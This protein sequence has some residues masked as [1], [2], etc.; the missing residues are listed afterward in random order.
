MPTINHACPYCTELLSDRLPPEG[1]RCTCREERAAAYKAVVDA[2]ACIAALESDLAAMTKERDDL[3][4]AV[5]V[6][7]RSI[8]TIDHWGRCNLSP[9]YFW[10]R[11]AADHARE[12]VKK[13]I[14]ANPI[15]RAAVEGAKP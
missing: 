8:N 6:L 4:E 7:G 5:R 13:A 11:H 15:A 12:E 1:T 2:P 9:E 10:D 14:L 3:R